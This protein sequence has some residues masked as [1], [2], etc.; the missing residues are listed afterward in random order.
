MPKIGMSKIDFGLIDAKFDNPYGRAENKHNALLMAEAEAKYLIELAALQ[1]RIKLEYEPQLIE[2]IPVAGENEDEVK[3]VGYE[4][5]KELLEGKK[6]VD[7]LYY[8]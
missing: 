3:D 6:G 2:N 1:T 8:T 7:N 5:T 4:K